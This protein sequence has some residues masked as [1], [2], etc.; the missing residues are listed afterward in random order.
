MRESEEFITLYRC[1]AGFWW[2][3]TQIVNARNHHLPAVE[4]YIDE[5]GDRGTSKKSSP[6]F[7]VTAV[8]IPDESALHLRTVVKGMRAE[9]GIPPGQALHWND[10]FRVRTPERRELAARL[11]AGIPGTTLSYVIVRKENIGRSWKMSDDGAIF[12]NYA[13]RLALERVVH[14]AAAWPGGPRRVVVRAG[15]V[16]HMDHTATADYPARVTRGAGSRAHAVVTPW[17]LL[18]WPPR[19]FGADRYDGIQAA[20]LYSGILR[21][22][23]DGADDDAACGRYL[24]RC[25]HQLRRSGSGRILGYGVKFIGDEGYLARRRWW[26]DLNSWT[27]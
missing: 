22:A 26:T 9:F 21:C 4:A 25:R 20:D 18:H 24:L 19:W 27:P 2:S 6:Y 23:L 3:S 15:S 7:A 5:T 16:R 17:H 14:T 8:V 1:R 11:L 13:I 12:Y 10:H